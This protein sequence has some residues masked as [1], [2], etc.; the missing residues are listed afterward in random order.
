[1][2]VRCLQAYT[3]SSFPNSQMESSWKS[4]KVMQGVTGKNTGK[5]WLLPLPTNPP[6]KFYLHTQRGE[7]AT[8]AI[9]T[10][11]PGTILIQDLSC[12]FAPGTK[13][14]LRTLTLGLG[15]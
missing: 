15:P 3:G 6:C 12:C 10:K 11:V 13:G 1:M 14:S 2:P 5:L 8:S 4:L 9:S 7:E